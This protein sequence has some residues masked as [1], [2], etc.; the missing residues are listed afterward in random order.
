MAHT[1]N[2]VEAMEAT[3]APQEAMTKAEPQDEHRW[4]QKFVGEW[5]VEGEAAMGPDQPP[6]K[7]SGTERVRSLGDFWVLAEGEGES[8]GG[9][10]DES[11]ITF[12][13]DPQRK[14]F[15]G[16]WIGSM[17][18]HLWVY[19]GTLDADGRV[20]TLE[21][22]GPSMAGDGTMATYRDVFEFK[23]DDHRVLTS[24]MPRDD[25]TWQQFMTVHYRRKK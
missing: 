6:A 24:H 5:T 13:Y 20:L 16:T 17:M 3:T 14:R 12:G 21:A 25:G 7:F 1:A 22:E 11:M 10:T 4:L 8:P 15:V 18:S 9:G 19:D 23:S 2:G